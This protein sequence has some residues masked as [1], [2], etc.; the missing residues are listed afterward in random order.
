MQKNIIYKTTLISFMTILAFLFSGCSQKSAPIPVKKLQTNFSNELGSENI[1]KAILNAAKK[2]GWEIMEPFSL[3]SKTLSLK[4]SFS[5][6]E[7]IQ[8]PQGRFWRKVM[9]SNDIFVNVVIDTQ[10]FKANITQ[11]SSKHLLSNNDKEDFNNHLKKLEKSI[12][13]ELIPLII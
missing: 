3:N 7:T 4:K 6:R 5:K 9:L 1:S 10:S 12:Y 13:L 11:E 2:N 8:N